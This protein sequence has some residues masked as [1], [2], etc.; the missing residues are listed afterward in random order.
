MKEI[1]KLFLDYFFKNPIFVTTNI[2]LSLSVPFQDIL[3]PHLYGN[4]IYAIENN[5]NILKPFIIVIV[6]ITI[7]QI[8]CILSDWHD[9]KLFPKIQQFIRIK[10]LESTFSNYEVQYQDDILIGDLMSKF[11]KIPVYITQLYER[12]KSHLL[13]YIIAY[14]LAV[15]YFIY[16]D[17]IL[18]I[19]LGILLITY[20]ILII[21][22][23]FYC[24]ERSICKDKI[25]NELNEEIDDIL[26]NLIS[27]YGSDEQET[28][29]K[30]IN[31]YEEKYSKAYKKTMTCILSTRIIIIPI[32]VIFLSIFCYRS[33]IGIN[34]KSMPPSKFAPLFII[35]LYILSSIM[36]LTDH[37]R[38]IIFEVGII[39]NF[40]DMFAHKFNNKKAIAIP[41]SIN[42]PNKGI[43][44][45]NVSFKYPSSVNET[46]SNFNLYINNGEKICIIG[47]IGSGKSTLLKLLLKLIEPSKGLLFLNGIQYNNISVKTLRKKIGYVPQQP[48]LFNRSILENIKYGNKNIKNEDI[49]IL[50]NQLG[51]NNEFSHLEFGLNTKIGKN[52][53]KISGGQRQL[54]WSLRILLNNPEILILDEPTASLDE[55]TT[56]LLIKLYDYFMKDKIIIMVTHDNTLMNYG[57]RILKMENGKL[58]NDYYVKNK[59]I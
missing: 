10:M 18:G 2:L 53:S 26:K 37:L 44:I 46:L 25:Q 28:E 16:H 3:L 59:E 4:I 41:P 39:S 57:S 52:G 33:I 7:I 22:S 6:I 48:I 36:D 13:P 56:L 9:T 32:I 51:L 27:V 19:S 38:D 11:I 8:I 49:I 40:E 17:K 47:E 21:G 58:I 35:L 34:N 55:K 14:I 24:K 45:S 42:I 30:R 15:I 1:I 54:L 23:P 29:I 31:I 5:Q 43:Y 20:I 50:L 12:I